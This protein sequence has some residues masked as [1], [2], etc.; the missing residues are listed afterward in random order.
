MSCVSCFVFCVCFFFAGR[1]RKVTLELTSLEGIFMHVVR[2]FFLFVFCFL[3][4]LPCCIHLV[5]KPPPEEMLRRARSSTTLLRRA[6]TWPS[7]FGCLLRF[8]FLWF[9]LPLLDWLVSGPI[10]ELRD[11]TRAEAR[12]VHGPGTPHEGGER[13]RRRE[14]RCSHRRRSR[15][16]LSFRLRLRVWVAESRHAWEVLSLLRRLKVNRIRVSAAPTCL[17]QT[18]RSEGSLCCS[19][20]VGLVSVWGGCTQFVHGRSR[21][22]IDPRIPTMPGPSASGFHQPG[23]H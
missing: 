17:L 4:Y 9:A 2:R 10:R 16:N 20:I 11:P 15:C 12:Q 13:E 5:S 21:M 19:V 23:R 22:I 6:H 7:F 8:A 1:W 3:L 18:I 14:E